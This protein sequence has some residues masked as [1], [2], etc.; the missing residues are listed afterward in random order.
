ML[1]CT[2]KKLC[3]FSLNDYPLYTP[4][5]NSVSDKCNKC[6]T[7]QDN[8]MKFNR[9]TQPIKMLVMDKNEYED[10]CQSIYKACFSYNAEWRCKC[11]NYTINCRLPFLPHIEKSPAIFFSINPRQNM[12]PTMVN[13]HNGKLDPTIFFPSNTADVQHIY[14]KLTLV[15]K[16]NFATGTR[17]RTRMIGMTTKTSSCTYVSP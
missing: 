15:F 10:M 8:L 4:G 16:D 2:V 7:L 3:R 5:V 6:W 17:T 1:S 12:T 14:L 13:Q 9:C 11:L